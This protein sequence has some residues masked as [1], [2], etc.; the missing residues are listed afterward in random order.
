MY[1]LLQLDTLKKEYQKEKNDL[2]SYYI[3]QIKIIQNNNTTNRALA[4]K[5]NR[6]KNNL[7]K[8]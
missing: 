7:I 6:H 8:S 2:Y 4:K 1:G 5:F 3:N